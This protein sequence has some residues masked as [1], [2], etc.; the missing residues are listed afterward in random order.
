MANYENI[1]D[2]GFD[3]KTAKEQRAIACMGG[4][5][6]GKARRR[7]AALRDA[8]NRILTMQVEVKGLSDILLADGGSSTYEEVMTMAMIQKA[9][10]GD[11][12]AYEAVMRVVG[13]TDKSEKDLREQELRIQKLQAEIDRLKRA[14]SETEDDGVTIINDAEEYEE[15][16]ADIGDH[17][18]ETPEDI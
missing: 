16:S 14:S 13:Q 17:D 18:T 5:A 15:D 12:K 2:H 11:V 9:M 8:A 3:K 4:I 10:Q 7:K 1:K 6:S